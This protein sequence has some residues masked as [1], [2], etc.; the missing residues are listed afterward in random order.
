MTSTHGLQ[1][2]ND[3]RRA[4]RRLCTIAQGCQAKQCRRFT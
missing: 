2:S 4:G 3:S 1:K